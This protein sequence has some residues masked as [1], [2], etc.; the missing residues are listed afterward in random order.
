MANIDKISLRGNTQQIGGDEFDG[1]WIDALTTISGSF[2]LAPDG[3]QVFSLAGYLPDSTYDYEVTFEITSSTGGSSGNYVESYI[4]S[5]NSRSS[6]A[7]RS[8]RMITR[9][10]ANQ[11]GGMTVVVPILASNQNVLVYTYSGS[12]GNSTFGLWARG[13]RRIGKNGTHSNYVSYID[14]Q[15]ENY[16]IGGDFLNGDWIPSNNEIL[17]NST[18]AKEEMQ[19]IDMSSFLPNDGQAYWVMISATVRTGASSGNAASVRIGH[20]NGMLDNPVVCQH[21]TRTN[22]N[23][24]CAGNILVPLT[25]RTLYI[26]NT[27]NATSGTIEVTLRGYRRI[28]TN[29]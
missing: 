1:Q 17:F 26:S 7:T 6:F 27:G 8:I 16:P 19:A 21:V 5:G 20:N 24:T 4:C 3:Q 2:T 12:N 10:S 9:A 28:G 23:M 22:S 29:A 25:G 14:Y 15:G 13:Y 18:L 11:I